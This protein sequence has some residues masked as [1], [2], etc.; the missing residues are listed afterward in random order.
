MTSTRTH[1]ATK[2]A[3]G[4]PESAG[5]STHAGSAVDKPPDPTDEA[6]TE[7]VMSQDNYNSKA[8]ARLMHI[9]DFAKKKEARRSAFADCRRYP[10]KSWTTFRGRGYIFSHTSWAINLWDMLL[11]CFIVYIAIYAPLNLAFGDRIGWAIEG[12]FIDY[13]SVSN[14]RSCGEVKPRRKSS[15]PLTLP[16]CVRARMCAV[17]ARVPCGRPVAGAG[18]CLPLRRAG[19]VAHL[20]HRPRLRGDRR[21]PDPRAVHPLLVLGR[22]DLGAPGTAHRRRPAARCRSARALPAEL[23]GRAA[24]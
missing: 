10:S 12:T 23:L 6:D 20:V 24:W 1:P 21:T 4:S 14:V 16:M 22:P 11:S 18:L 9:I 7:S 8:Q 3:A 15:R 5:T 19:Q 2:E 13:K 17:R